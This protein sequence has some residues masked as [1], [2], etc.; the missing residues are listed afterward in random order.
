MHLVLIPLHTQWHKTFHSHSTFLMF[1]FHSKTKCGKIPQ[2]TPFSYILNCN[3][4]STLLQIFW[5]HSCVHIFASFSLTLYPKQCSTMY[6]VLHCMPQKIS[7][8]S[9]LSYLHALF[10]TPSRSFAHMTLWTCAHCHS[11]S[12]SLDSQSSQ[13]KLVSFS[14]ILALASHI[15]LPSTLSSTCWIPITHQQQST[16]WKVWMK[17]IWIW[18]P[19]PRMQV[20]HMAASFGLRNYNA[21][22][23][24]EMAG[25]HI[26]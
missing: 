15:H 18:P 25:V 7:S 1:W 24:K 20:E 26:L 14:A 17:Q 11:C 21:T 5:L 22:L 13:L 2:L 3:P 10:S 6:K 16:S 19:Q 23:M 8:S 4:Y 12:C 9:V